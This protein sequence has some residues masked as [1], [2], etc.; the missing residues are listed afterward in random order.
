MDLHFHIQTSDGKVAPATF[1]AELTV[2]QLI[3]EFVTDENMK[4]KPADPEAWQLF[5]EDTGENLDPKKSLQQNGVS[6]GHRL[7]LLPNK[8]EEPLPGTTPPEPGSRIMKRCDNGHYFDPKKH[9][10]C[11]FCGVAEIKLEARS[12][13]IGSSSDEH[14]RPAGSQ[15]SQSSSRMTDDAVTRALPLVQ[16][17][18]RIDPVVG[19]LV[20]IGGPE[21]GKDYR[22]RSENNT[23]GRSKDMYICISG[24]DL[25][26]RE[27]HTVITFDPQRNAFHL[28]P[29]EG[30]GLVYVNGEVV[31]AHKQ[32]SA[33][34]EILLGK[35]KLTFVPLCGDK[36]KWE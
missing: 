25:I 35:T 31:L 17:E 18:S 28:S 11:P 22:I 23:I 19:W 16:G 14:T 33:F 10:T 24:D 1:P 5:D 32:L 3:N 7:K 27:R 8:R 29:G 20:A 30:R 15:A 9:T 34:D 4:I 12:L 21:K 36:F 26:S 2:R 6:G 13:K